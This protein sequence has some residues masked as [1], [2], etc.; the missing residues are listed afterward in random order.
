ME[1][2]V[3]HESPVI[4]ADSPLPDYPAD[5]LAL[6]LPPVTVDVR[7]IAS[8]DGRIERVESLVPPDETSRPFHEATS[9]A[10]LRWEFSPLRRIENGFATEV[11]FHQKYRFVFTQVDGKADVDLQP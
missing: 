7:V 6:R 9:E 4:L 5:Q 2:G 10:L 11:P 1:L 8:P 3:S